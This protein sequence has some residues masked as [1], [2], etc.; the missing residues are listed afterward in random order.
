MKNFVGIFAT[1]LLTFSAAIAGP[2]GAAEATG[3]TLQGDGTVASPWQISSEADL[4]LSS[5]FGNCTYADRRFELTQDIAL[6]G[7]WTPLSFSGGAGNLAQFDGKGYTI[8]GLNVIQGRTLSSGTYTEAG[9]FGYLG[10]STIKDLK[11]TG[12]SVVTDGSY[13]GGLAGK[14]LYSSIENV[15][16]SLTGSVIGTAT[17]HYVGGL[18]GL[19]HGSTITNSTFVA[20]SVECYQFCGGA[21]G[22]IYGALNQPSQLSAVGV[23]TNV[24]GQYSA[25]AFAGNLEAGSSSVEIS[26]SFYKGEVR[27]DNG[28]GA[29]FGSDDNYGHQINIKNNAISATVRDLANSSV[30]KSLHKYTAV[31][32]AGSLNTVQANHL[33]VKYLVNS[34]SVRDPISLH[35]EFLGQPEASRWSEVDNVTEGTGQSTAVSGKQLYRASVTSLADL[36]DSWK[37]NGAAV[38]VQGPVKVNAASV[39]WVIDSRVNAPMNDGR[40][41]PSALY[42]LGFFGATKVPCGIGT[43]SSDGGAP[44]TAAPAG[45]YVANAAATEALPCQ[46][47]TY[48]S[49]TGQSACVPATAGFYVA[50]SGASSQVP[51]A[52]GYTSDQQAIVCTPIQSQS[53][54]SSSTAAPSFEKIDIKSE[55][56]K[57]VS[58][59]GKDLTKLTNLKIGKTELVFTKSDT[60]VSFELP[61]ELA[62]GPHDLE[63]VWPD[64]SSVVRSALTIVQT[65]VS[66]K[67]I[68][69]KPGR[70]SS[71]IK[72][73]GNKL[74]V[75]AKIPA[76]TVIKINGKIVA[77]QKTAGTLRAL[78]S[79]KKGTNI[80]SIFVANKKV[81]QQIFVR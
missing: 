70:F 9:L 37:A 42:N 55:P 5:N 21:A 19:S 14:A 57:R 46:P 41:M 31:L 18:V 61:A 69:T 20:S 72:R 75:T 47:G 27:G 25:G 74:S 63:L 50:N 30:I 76:A 49:Q 71:F 64:G 68:D 45:R 22:Q 17:S 11:V 66:P 1:A 54:G 33:R 80:V 28:A 15:S 23:A 67:P 79:L 38:A 73:V 2:V 43:Y 78:I 3:C 44:C 13:V 24:H 34:T 10:Y 60:E 4:A 56:G 62:I 58:F 81:R 7:N 26:N 48:Q 59:K 51:C 77:S 6:A 32:N 40:P 16:V 8:S 12:L 36:P 53:S 35:E 52:A 65:I 29:I 39:R